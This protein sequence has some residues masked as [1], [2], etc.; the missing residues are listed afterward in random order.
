MNLEPDEVLDLPLLY[1]EWS[2]F[3]NNRMLF[4]QMAERNIIILSALNDVFSCNLTI[5]EQFTAH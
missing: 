1:E 3:K 5:F 2:T 4:L